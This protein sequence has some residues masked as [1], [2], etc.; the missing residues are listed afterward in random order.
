AVKSLLA[1]HST[2]RFCSSKNS[3]GADSR[4]GTGMA[5]LPSPRQWCGAAYLGGSTGP[6]WVGHSVPLLWK[7]KAHHCRTTPVA[8]TSTVLFQWLHSSSH[9][10]RHHRPLETRQE[11]CWKL[12][13]CGLY[14]YGICYICRLSCVLGS[15][16]HCQFE[17]RH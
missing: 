17:S 2:H 13:K 15:P 5:G 16:C 3:A 11:V 8:S 12:G 1:G 4:S 10:C 7:R 14:I 9:C 6:D